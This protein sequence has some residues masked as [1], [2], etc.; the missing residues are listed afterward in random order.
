[1]M[2]WALSTSAQ[3]VNY[4]TEADNP[5]DYMP[6]LNINLMIAGLDGSYTNFEGMYFYAGSHGQFMLNNSMGIQWN[7]NRSWMNLGRLGFPDYKAPFDANAG[8]VLYFTNTSRTR[9]LNVILKSEAG[10]KQGSTI[11]TSIKV[12]GTRN[13]QW[14]IHGGLYFKSQAYG[15]GDTRFDVI[16]SAGLEH[17]NYK[18]TALYGGIIR[19][20]LTNLI[21]N[22]DTYGKRFNSLGFE[23]YMDALLT[24]SNRFILLDPDVVGT[25][26]KQGQ[27]I[28]EIVKPF[29][30]SSPIGFRIGWNGYQIAPKSVTNKKFGGSYNFEV[31]KMP[32]VGIY[33]RG[34]IGLT[35]VKK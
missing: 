18:C 19:R 13:F 23:T 29:A 16:E 25:E 15:F 11:T 2:I 3:T 12:P 10:S 35:I 6:R 28:T 24:F 9:Q 27:N 34:G 14:G 4:T 33:V 30:D 21:L 1:M 17:A 22:V 32:Y 31:G 8:A 5:A 7:V 20:R 26:F